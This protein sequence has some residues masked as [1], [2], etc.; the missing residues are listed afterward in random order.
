VPGGRRNSHRSDT[1]GAGRRTPRRR[2]GTRT[3]GVRPRAKTARTPC[4]RHPSQ[5]LERRRVDRIYRQDS[6][7]DFSAAQSVG[8]DH[9]TW[10]VTGTGHRVQIRVAFRSID[11]TCKANCGHDRSDNRPGISSA[12]RSIRPH[13]IC[14]MTH[15]CRPRTAYVIQQE[16]L[17]N[18]YDVL[19][20]C[21]R[22]A[23]RFYVAES[24]ETRRSPPPRPLT[25]DTGLRRALISRYMVCYI[26]QRDH[27]P[28]SSRVE[29]RC[30][31][32]SSGRCGR[33]TRGGPARVQRRSPS[34]RSSTGRRAERPSVGVLDPNGR[35]T[36]PTRVHA[37]RFHIERSRA[38]EPLSDSG[39]RTR[40]RA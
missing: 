1:S 30:P 21:C 37:R 7:G 23:P 8:F 29:P 36:L 3:F 35:Y 4:R 11:P 40:P 22:S 33:Y 13:P 10:P 24:V 25:I 20:H 32:A 9:P 12:S 27:S 34:A 14:F 6:L 19:G 17:A 16:Y 26:K 15:P 2:R 31:I 38:V 5:P 39:R 18:R 28:F